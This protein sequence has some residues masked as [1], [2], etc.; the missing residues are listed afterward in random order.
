MGLKRRRIKQSDSLQDRLSQF[1]E[2]MKRQA[3]AKPDGAEK[4]EL[5]KKVRTAEQA[6]DMDRQLRQ[7]Y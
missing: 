2:D 4:D 5:L 7:H 3:E 1:A 6:V